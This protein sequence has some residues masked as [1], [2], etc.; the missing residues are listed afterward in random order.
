MLKFLGVSKAAQ[1]IK[2]IHTYYVLLWVL[3]ANAMQEDGKVRDVLLWVL[4]ANAIQE[5]GEG[6]DV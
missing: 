6:R 5:H 3:Y 2:C 1:V 4:Y